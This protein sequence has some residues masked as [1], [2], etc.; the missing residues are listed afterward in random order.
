MGHFFGRSTR[1]CRLLSLSPQ[2]QES[3]VIYGNSNCNFSVL[4]PWIC[5]LTRVY[6]VCTVVLEINKKIKNP[7][8]KHSGDVIDE[9]SDCKIC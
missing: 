1:F 5:A 3:L 4:S 8:Q 2:L 6:L 9:Y 7:V